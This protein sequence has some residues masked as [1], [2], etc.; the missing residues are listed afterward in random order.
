MRPL[1]LTMQAFGSYAQRTLVDFT[2]PNQNLFLITGDTGAGKTTIFDA[3]VFAIY[4]E[5]SSGN[6]KKDGTELQSQYADYETEPYVELTFS[7]LSGTET[8]IYTVRR[9]PRHIRPLKKGSGTREEKE[10]VSLTMPD[11]SDYSRNQRETDDKLEKIVGLTKS[12]F[13]QVAMIAQGEFM[14]VLRADSNRK[15]EIFRKLFG[16]ERFQEI[17]DELGL[18]RRAK[19]SEMEQIQTACRT[20]TSH[21]VIPESYAG[22][23]RLKE[24]K[25]RVLSAEK[26]NVTDMEALLN[27]LEVLCDSLKKER[28]SAKAD[29]DETSKARDEKRDAYTNAQI[30]VQSFEQ[31]E[32][33]E[34]ELAE[35]EASEEEM[36]GAARLIEEIRAAYE[37][38]AVYQRYSDAEA[39]V[40]DMEKKLSSLQD[41]LPGLAGKYAETTAEETAARAAQ[42]KQLEA[43]TKVSDRVEK[44]MEVFQ[45][46]HVA[47]EEVK[48]RQDALMTAVEGAEKAQKALADF[49]AQERIWR[50]QADDLGDAD[51]LL[52]RWT[53]KSEEAQEITREVAFAQS[54]QRDIGIWRIKVQEAQRDYET[55]RENYRIKKEEYDRK[56]EA[57]LDAQAG[58]IA[59]RLIPGKPCPVCGSTLHPHPCELS[60]EYEELTRES[61]E[62]LAGQ[63]SQLEQE[64][65]GK[66]TA[67]GAAARLLT[68]KQ[69]RYEDTI[70]RLRRR[71]AKSIGNVP[72]ELTVGQAEVLLADWKAEIA[73]EGESLREKADRLVQV[74]EC[75][76]DADIQRT[77]RKTDFETALQK[78]ADAKAGLACA[79]A[80]LKGLEEQREYLTEEEAEAALAAA[81][82][83]KEGTDTAYQAAHSAAQRAKTEK[84]NA[85][86]WIRQACEAL[87]GLREK[88]DGCKAAYGEILAEKEI[89]RFCWKEITAQYGREEAGFLQTK[90]EAHSRRK[91]S[92]TGAAQTARIAIGDRK[93]PVIEELEMVKDEAERRLSE[94]QTALEQVKEVY[95]VNQSAYHALAPRMEERSRVI[96]EYARIDSLYN[97]LAG[98]VTGARMD[99]ETFVQ[100]CYLQR[101]LYA[102]NIRFRKMSAGAF[103]L[104]MV[105]EDQAGEGKNRGLDLMVYS[106]VTAQ[107]RE[108]RTLSGGESFMAALSLALGMAD[109]IQENAASINLDIMFIDE[110]FGSLDEHSRD[111]AVR[112]LQ[113]MAGGSK[114][115]GIIS[116][117]TELKQEIEDQLL[118]SKDE[119]GSHIR[120]QIS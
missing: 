95:R 2:R 87:P 89:A 78:S 53:K 110:G 72:E 77:K 22:A 56:R 85:Q 14:E 86:A 6:N 59:Q 15:K 116:H 103:E 46:I 70:A 114:L 100:R 16:T 35:C 26:L 34:R 76:R 8:K 48:A 52:E 73:A 47:E 33:A 41:A 79:G 98:K 40:A 93:K 17:V 115:I 105:G 42:E 88:R 71:M 31:L 82:L 113:Q 60:G 101:I 3:I 21:V 74:Q 27:E 37:I 120:W 63:V 112:V 36:K 106:F 119:E 108:V 104:R 12:Q 81:K 91:A 102:A 96:Q 107:E 90:L 80:A 58:F 51:I 5:A 69:S 62:A 67:S 39:A 13:M 30:L 54:E 83:A 118:V 23:E 38:K 55:A 29:Y 50:K 111:Q 75:L 64:R 45:K 57:F 28:D 43:F 117:V 18:R 84:E 94:V 7:E 25:S 92:A 1:V 9:V 11:G 24:L 19:L 61:I 32:K 10:T 99:I 109:Q 97:R 49:E 44:A 20:E 4:G 68:E 66:S 65:A